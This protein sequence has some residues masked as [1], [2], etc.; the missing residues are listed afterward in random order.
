MTK[1]IASLVLAA[2]IVAG[3]GSTQA[4]SI[5]GNGLRDA[6]QAGFITTGGVFDGR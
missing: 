3:I 1:I 2:S 5:Y 4:G 6:A